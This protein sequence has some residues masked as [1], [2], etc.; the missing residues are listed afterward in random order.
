MSLTLYCPFLE[1]AENFFPS[2]PLY[3]L[4][5]LNANGHYKPRKALSRRRHG[6]KS[7]RGRSYS[8]S[9]AF[10]RNLRPGVSQRDRAVEDERAGLR[11]WINTKVSLP[12][13]LIAIAYGSVG[14]PW[15]NSTSRHHCQ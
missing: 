10:L 12:L 1:R 9:T 11:V 14:K 15:L 8:F 5:L 7:R 6:C 13:K 2:S 4:L 3:Q